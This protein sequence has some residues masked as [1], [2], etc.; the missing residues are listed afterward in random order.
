MC[1]TVMANFILNSV[2]QLQK[3]HD[4]NS[5]I[6]HRFNLAR[7]S[8]YESAPDL[9]RKIDDAGLLFTVDVHCA[10][11]T[12]TAKTPNRIYLNTQVKLSVHLLAGFM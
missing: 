10:I 1:T 2:V 4:F 11:S 5:A 6:L 8:L 12:S 7:N 9:L 3:F